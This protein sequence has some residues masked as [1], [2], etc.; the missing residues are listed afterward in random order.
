MKK[1]I[2]SIFCCLL[3]A[4]PLK[5]AIP[6]N[7]SPYRSQLYP[8]WFVGPLFTPNPLE[9]EVHHPGLETVL[10]ALHTEGEYTNKGR[11]DHTNSMWTVGP[12]I[13]YQQS[14]NEWFGYEVIGFLVTNIKKG[15]TSTHLKDTILRL[16]FQISRDKK[17]TWIPDFRIL[18]QETFPTGK[19][20]KSN[21]KKFE[22]D[23]T[24]QGSFQSGLHL[25]FQKLFNISE[26]HKLRIRFTTGFFFPSSVHVKGINYYG[27][28]VDTSGKVAPGQ[29]STTYFTSEL[30][31]TNKCSLTL[32]TNYIQG[33]QGKF[34]NKSSRV[35]DMKIPAYRQLTLA[36]ELQ[37]TISPNLGFLGGLWFS[38]YGRNSSSFSSAFISLLY[39]F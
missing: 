39:I 23:L 12:Y 5:A 21:P 15:I 24:G 26:I 2:F 34:S 11:I 3:Q 29:Y 25:A 28:T 20:Q 22:T 37:Y 17:A 35:N 9:L 1:L 27:G 36:P 10:V 33:L 4:L 13:D 38:V 8:Q 14:L 19:Y 32:E 30:S 18:F 31:I 6:S 16:G 7:S